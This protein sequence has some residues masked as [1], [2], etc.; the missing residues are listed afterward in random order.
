MVT[1]NTYLSRICETLLFL[2]QTLQ[3]LLLDYAIKVERYVCLLY[4]GQSVSYSLYYQ[5]IL[6]ICERLI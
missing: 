5:T 6:F 2:F 3:L 1:Q 4:V